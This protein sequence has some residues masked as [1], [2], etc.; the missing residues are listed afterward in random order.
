MKTKFEILK[1]AK[2]DVPDL[3]T[4]LRDSCVSNIYIKF[5]CINDFWHFCM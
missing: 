4:Y 1:L 2:D 5:L 3:L